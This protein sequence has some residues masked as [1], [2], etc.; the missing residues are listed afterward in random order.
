MVETT[1]ELAGELAM[2][3]AQELGYQQIEWLAD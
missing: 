2:L 1:M 3:L